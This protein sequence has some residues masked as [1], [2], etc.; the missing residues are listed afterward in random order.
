MKNFDSPR[1][2]EWLTVWD[3]G[4]TNH[5]FGAKSNLFRFKNYW[6][7]LP[8]FETLVQSSWTL[9]PHCTTLLVLFSMK[10]L[11]LALKIWDKNKSQLA[12]LIHHCN[13]VLAFMD[14]IEEYKFL[15]LPESNFRL[16]L[17][18]HLQKLIKIQHIY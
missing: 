4:S 14:K 16:I 7:L 13:L 18:A 2:L 5:Y 11:R 6:P 1:F 17:K 9:I 12:K 3:G 8:G 10:K 15:S